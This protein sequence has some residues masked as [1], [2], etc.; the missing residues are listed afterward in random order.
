MAK[1]QGSIIVES[2]RCKG[3]EVCIAACPTDAIR[4][5]KEVNAMG[6]P[7]SYLAFPER[8]IGC[9]GCALVCPDSCITVY[10]AKNPNE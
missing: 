3:C 2:D 7:Y 8:C 5:H 4:L 6:Y 10:R 1:I 9:A